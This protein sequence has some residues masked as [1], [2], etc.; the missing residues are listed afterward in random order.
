[1]T[2]TNPFALLLIAAALLFPVT[3]T[4]QAASPAECPDCEYERSSK[5]ET[6]DERIG[7]LHVGPRLGSQKGSCKEAPAAGCEPDGADCKVPSR[8]FVIAWEPPGYS[9]HTVEMSTN[10]GQTFS[11]MGYIEL[12]DQ[13]EENVGYEGACDSKRDDIIIRVTVTGGDLEPMVATWRVTLEC[14][15]CEEGARP[16]PDAPV[17]F[18]QIRTMGGRTG[19]FQI[20]ALRRTRFIPM[21]VLS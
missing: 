20:D 11:T 12:F 6:G 13:W 16:E 5:H 8:V 10:N 19:V 3:A 7:D 1:M 17:V 4:A 9:A 18:S 14:L 2:K 15:E 21:A